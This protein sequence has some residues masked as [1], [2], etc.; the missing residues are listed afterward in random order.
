[1]SSLTITVSRQNQFP[2]DGACHID[3]PFFQ[4]SLLLPTLFW[5][6][7]HLVGVLVRANLKGG[8]VVPHTHD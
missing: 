6:K 7:D 8:S 3:D 2:L 5:V 4:A 1:M